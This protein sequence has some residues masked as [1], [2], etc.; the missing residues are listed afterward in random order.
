MRSSFEGEIFTKAK[1]E[2]FLLFGAV[3]DAL[4]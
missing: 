2:W 1:N 3:N 4:F